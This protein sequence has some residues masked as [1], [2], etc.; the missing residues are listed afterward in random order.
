MRF[1]DVDAAGIVFYARVFDYFHD[2]YVS[3]LHGRG[4]RLDEALRDGTWAAPLRH[5]EADYLRPLHF[6]DRIDVVIAGIDVAET[7]YT[8]GYRVERD[9]EVVCVGRVVHVAVDPSEGGRV[10][11]P[12]ELRDAL[13]G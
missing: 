10:P 11:V 7:E 12:A 5:A 13:T 8:V 3:F 4:A 9:G 6:G 1:Q 2:A